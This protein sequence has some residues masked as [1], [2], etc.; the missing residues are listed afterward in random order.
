MKKFTAVLAMLVIAGL[1]AAGCG[2]GSS[3]SD[4]TKQVESDLKTLIADHP[5][6]FLNDDGSLAKTTGCTFKSGNEFVCA[7]K[8]NG[9][10]LFANVTDDGNS[11]EE[12][13][14]TQ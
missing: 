8:H 2:G 12:D 3:S 9:K 1:F 6:D 4:R 7:V 13:G 5:K 10:E 14:F 11:I